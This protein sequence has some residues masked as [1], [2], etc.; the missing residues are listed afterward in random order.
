MLMNKLFV[1]QERILPFNSIYTIRDEKSSEIYIK[2]QFVNLTFYKCVFLKSL[3]FNF[4]LQ[5]RICYGVESLRQS[6][7]SVLISPPPTFNI[8]DYPT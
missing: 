1:T 5:F 8:F 7:P 2:Y 3:I 6:G 4:D